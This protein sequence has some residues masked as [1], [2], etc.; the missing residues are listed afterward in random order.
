[1]PASRG[2]AREIVCGNTGM[3]GAAASHAGQCANRIKSGTQ[4]TQAMPEGRI[5]AQ[6]AEVASER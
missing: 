3:P 5:D 6:C 2:G 4:H 1:M